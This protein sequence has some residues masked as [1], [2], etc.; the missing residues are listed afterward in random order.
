MLT[1]FHWIVAGFLFLVLVA[2]GL[3]RR[4]DRPTE[5]PKP[6]TCS[7]CGDGYEEGELIEREF[8]SGYS[9]AICGRCA[10]A[11]F[12]DAVRRGLTK[13]DPQGDSHA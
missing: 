5:E 12:N 8:T 10:T 11:L 1:P 6:F 4:R 9:H 3:A 13:S 2:L 7:I